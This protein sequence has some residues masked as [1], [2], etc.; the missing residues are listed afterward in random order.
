MQQQLDSEK[1]SENMTFADSNE[2]DSDEEHK[3][4]DDVLKLINLDDA[5][6]FLRVDLE[7]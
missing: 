2:L 6:N 3:N 7:E 1:Q 5:S 4:N